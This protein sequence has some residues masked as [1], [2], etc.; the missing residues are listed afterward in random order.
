MPFKDDF[1]RFKYSLIRK[2]NSMAV[3]EFMEGGK[4][5][6]DKS[7]ETLDNAVKSNS[8]AIL[9]SLMFFLERCGDLPANKVLE[10]IRRLQDK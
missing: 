3:A 1:N 10:Q 2:V 8:E 5:K 4:L 6:Y 9:N 7:S